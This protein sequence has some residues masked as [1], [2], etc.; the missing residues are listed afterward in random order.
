MRLF[1][2]RRVFRGS[3]L[4]ASYGM[5][6][7]VVRFSEDMERQFP[8]YVKNVT[9]IGRLVSNHTIVNVDV[10]LE[11]NDTMGGYVASFDLRDPGVYTLQVS[12]RVLRVT[13]HVA[14]VVTV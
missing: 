4:T 12:V 2:H 6:K 14:C 5:N 13:A 10:D 9:F 8:D 3:T 1:S 7:F 11:Y